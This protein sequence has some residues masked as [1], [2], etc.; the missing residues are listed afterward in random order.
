MKI[1][2]IKNLPI[3][4]VKVIRFAKFLDFR[5]YFAETLRMSDIETLPELN[6][7]KPYPIVQ[8][9]ESF[10][11]KNVIKG[12]HFQ[13]DPP[14]GKLLRTVQGHMVDMVLDIRNGSPTLGKIILYDMPAS[15]EEDFNEWIWL[16]PGVAHGSFFLEETVTEY[17]F[18]ATYNSAAE[19]GIC[20]LSPDLDW[21]LADPQLTGQYAALQKQEF[22]IN[23]KDR[24][25]ASFQGWMSDKR[26]K[27]FYV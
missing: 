16:P 7:L 19:A 5:G 2:E 14:L 10:S 24:N 1:L 25:A 6:F 9:N 8:M 12:L 17:F 27:N 15:R 4:G 23:D 21:S 26:S 18:T 22:L 3:K 11:R 20:P 13:W